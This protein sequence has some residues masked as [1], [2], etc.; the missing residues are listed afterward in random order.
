MGHSWEIT[1]DR[2]AEAILALVA[3]FVVVALWA[4]LTAP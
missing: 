3:V 2:G 4:K 1:A